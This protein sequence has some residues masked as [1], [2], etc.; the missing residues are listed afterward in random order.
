VRG[1]GGRASTR[2][3]A[4][5]LGSPP[6]SIRGQLGSHSIGGRP[7]ALLT[8]AYGPSRGLWQGLRAGLAKWAWNA[9]PSHAGQVYSS[10]WPETVLSGPQQWATSKELLLRFR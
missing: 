9:P 8:A 7:S 5:Y 10:C 3:A 6:A 2:N 4:N 1:R